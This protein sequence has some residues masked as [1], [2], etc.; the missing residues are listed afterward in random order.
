MYI[1]FMSL[2]M[3][4]FM[5][6]YF[7]CS[8][9]SRR[10]VFFYNSLI[11][12][13]KHVTNTILM[14]TSTSWL[15]D[16]LSTGSHRNGYVYGTPRW[17]SSQRRQLKGPRPQTPRESVR[18]ETSW[19]SLEQLPRR[20]IPQNWLQTI[21]N[22]RLCLLSRGRNLYRLCRRRH[23]PWLVR[24]AIVWHNH[25]TFTISIS[26]SKIEVIQRIMLG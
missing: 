19:T 9:V 14:V 13:T 17:L 3:F 26:T 10:N 7:I 22:W 11:P 20:Q 4:P 24:R 23:L 12:W 5:L 1:F 18:T 2:F 15:C 16:G 21:S 8:S 25:G 6:T